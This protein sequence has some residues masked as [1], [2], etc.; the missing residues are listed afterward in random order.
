MWPYPWGVLN[1]GTRRYICL[2][3][4]FEHSIRMNT[5]WQIV[6]GVILVVILLA[7]VYFQYTREGF[8]TMPAKSESPATCN[9]LNVIL[10]KTQ[11]KFDSIK[12]SGN[13][14]D[15]DLTTKMIKSIQDEITKAK[16]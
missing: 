13:Q 1:F 10:E 15:I 5:N 12:D 14:T 7:Y 6:L 9:M 2:K 8:Q 16:C 4:K 11:K 3:I